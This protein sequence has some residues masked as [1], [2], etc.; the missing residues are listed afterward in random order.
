MTVSRAQVVAEA[1]TW[2]GTPWVHQHR[3][4]GIAVDCAGLLIGVARTL[5]I[6]PP[7]MDVNGYARQADGTLLAHCDRWMRRIQQADLQPGDV[8]ELGVEGFPDFIVNEA[9]ASGSR[10]FDQVSGRGFGDTRGRCPP[11]RRT[12]SRSH[13]PTVARSA[14]TS[15]S[16]RAAN[17]RK[18]S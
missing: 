10:F 14:A 8:I 6:V 7:D 9:V 1:R 4:K 11:W 15:R 3:S 2:L 18:T 16:R 17:L 12:I 5:G 13:C